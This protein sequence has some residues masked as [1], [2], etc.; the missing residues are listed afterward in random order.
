[1][2]GVWTRIHAWL[3]A[4]AP[5]GPLAPGG[6]GRFRIV[7]AAAEPDTVYGEVLRVVDAVLPKS[8]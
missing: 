7:D 6:P 4:N 5:A 3:D 1:M 8:S 2:K